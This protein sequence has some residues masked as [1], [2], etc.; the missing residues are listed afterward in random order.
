M[1]LVNA[2]TIDASG[3]N[4]LVIDTGSNVVTNSGTLEATG[5]GG[6]VVNSAVANS[7]T[8]WANRGNLT[9]NGAVSGNGAA[10]IDGAATL[11]FGA[12]SS[13]NTVF[14]DGAAG[15]LKLDQSASFSGT[16][17][18][19]AAGNAIDLADLGFGGAMTLG[20]AAN[21]G[22]S[23]GILTMSDGTHTAS[24]AL[25]GQ[26]AASGFHAASDAGAGTM[27]AYVPEDPSTGGLL[28]KP[29]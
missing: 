13:A 24:L 29:V 5:S 23:G 17:S 14:G 8:L 22:G 4:A 12:G 16:V 11:E 25:L 28:T 3:T 9:V 18:G 7:G 2:G 6:L 10:V 19:F 1:T 27:I 15:T 26:Y 21:A 20:Y